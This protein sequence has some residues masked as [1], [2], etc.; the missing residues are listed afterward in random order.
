M[1]GMVSCAGRN[2]TERIGDRQRFEAMS[3]LD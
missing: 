3:V 1:V 2:I